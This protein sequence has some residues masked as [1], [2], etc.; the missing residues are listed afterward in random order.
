MQ[1]QVQS[2]D[3]GKLVRCQRA[4]P[5]YVSD[6]LTVRALVEVNERIRIQKHCP[7]RFPVP[8]IT[9]AKRADPA[10]IIQRRADTSQFKVDQR[11]QLRVF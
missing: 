2:A 11:Q 1:T 6:F 7:R 3:D 5:F 9:I 10:N 4:I 8:G